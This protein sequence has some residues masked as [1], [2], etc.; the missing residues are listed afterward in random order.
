MGNIIPQAGETRVLFFSTFGRELFSVPVASV[1]AA[2][3]ADP[4]DPAARRLDVGPAAG[5]GGVG[6]G[7]DVRLAGRRRKGGADAMAADDHG[8]IYFGLLAEGLV[9]DDGHFFFMG[10]PSPP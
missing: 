4:A 5:G 8:N 7:G 9:I 6:G 1:R 3:A 10:T 2:F